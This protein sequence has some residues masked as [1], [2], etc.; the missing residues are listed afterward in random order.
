MLDEEDRTT[1]AKVLVVD[2]RHV[3]VGSHN[4]TRSA[5][6]ANREWSVEIDDAVIAHHIQAE[7]SS[8]PGW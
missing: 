5:L 6:A 3:I 8:L 7:L 1:H 4:W 2:D